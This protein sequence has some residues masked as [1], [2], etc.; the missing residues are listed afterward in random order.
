MYIRTIS[1]ANVFNFLV[2]GV[3][4]V[5]PRAV[6]QPTRTVGDSVPRG[7]SLPQPTGTQLRDRARDVSE[8]LK[9][10]L[11]G[12]AAGA[13]AASLVN[14]PAEIRATRAVN[15]QTSTVRS[16]LVAL[17]AGALGQ[18]T[19]LSQAPSFSEVTA[20]SFTVNGSSISVDP[21]T[22]TIASVLSRV[23]AAN[24]GVTAYFNTN[25]S[26][27]VFTP[28]Q[29]GARV[30]LLS[31]TSGF[32]AAAEISQGSRGAGVNPANPFN[33]TGASDPLFD[34]GQAVTAGSFQVNGI[35]IT[36][37]ANDTI[38]K[39]LD[40]I[41]SSFAGVTATFDPVTETVN[42][43]SKT[44]GAPAI[45]L[46]G[47]TSGFLAAVK[48]DATAQSRAGVLGAAGLADP[49]QIRSDI[50]SGV[51][52]VNAAV[53]ELFRTDALPADGASDLRAA[54][55][56]A[57]ANGSLGL[58]KAVAVDA[59]SSVPQ[60]RIDQEA[61][62]GVLNRT[63]AEISTFVASFTALLEAVPATMR[64][65]GEAAAARD[66]IGRLRNDRG[67]RELMQLQPG[68]T[69]LLERALGGRV[70]SM[71]DSAVIDPT[72]A[73]DKRLAM[74]A[75]KAKKAYGKDKDE[76]T[77]VVGLGAGNGDK[78]SNDAGRRVGPKWST[79]A[80]V[81]KPATPSLTSGD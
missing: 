54:I 62:Q 33:G 16:S 7:E 65:V 80:G 25:D 49:I 64:R 56:S 44:N 57:F 53:R 42:L 43:I 37:Q 27:V 76:D 22:D 6:A 79:A 41:T 30:S 61:L 70:L 32:L 11:A 77:K 8:D 45:T 36:V 73:N 19:L 21:N 20:G 60:F 78:V 67:E 52:K 38:Y 47:D 74:L 35:S 1:R 75:D 14:R 13:S 48:L 39:V 9:A 23:N 2:D 81:P 29:P 51:G 17:D 46:A 5:G 55:T 15:E 4:S 58:D 66:Q 28:T 72:E 59:T 31:D 26:K 34:P 50:T 18:G 68:T 40:K 3:G 71:L 12:I 63:P 69:E 24:A 10:L